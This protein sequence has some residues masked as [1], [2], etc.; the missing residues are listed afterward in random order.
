MVLEMLDFVVDLRTKKL[1]PNPASSETY[2]IDIFMEPS[3]TNGY[4]AT[5]RLNAFAKFISM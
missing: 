5:R 4:A 2:M 1:M 3:S